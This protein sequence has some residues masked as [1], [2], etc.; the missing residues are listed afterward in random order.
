MQCACTLMFELGRR[1]GRSLAVHCVVCVRCCDAFVGSGVCD[2]ERY[3]P[4]CLSD[5]RGALRAN[6]SDTHGWSAT[7]R[8]RPG[9]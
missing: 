4:T 3:A 9:R 8:S 6:A 1:M 7:R 2:A 5:V